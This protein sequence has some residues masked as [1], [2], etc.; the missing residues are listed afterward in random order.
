MLNRTP[1]R[2]RKGYKAVL[3]QKIRNQGETDTLVNLGHGLLPPS[4]L[5]NNHLMIMPW[6]TPSL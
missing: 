4:C 1:P 3:Q 6:L 5:T 2:T